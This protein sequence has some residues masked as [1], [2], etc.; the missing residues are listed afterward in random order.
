MK[1]FVTGLLATMVLSWM[2]EHVW[3]C[4]VAPI[5]FT[6]PQKW[7][8]TASGVY[9]GRARKRANDNPNSD[10]WIVDVSETLKGTPRTEISASAV[11]LGLCPLPNPPRRGASVLVLADENGL[12]FAQRLDLSSKYAKELRVLK[13]SAQSNPTVERDAR[14]SGA[15]PSP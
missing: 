7:F 15:R 12:A 8:E 5:Y 13:T 10:L 3:A 4:V 1:L 14:K 6:S 9:F 11:S 2:P